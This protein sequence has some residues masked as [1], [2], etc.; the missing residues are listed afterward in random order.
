M[1]EENYKKATILL[2]EIAT[3]ER[4]LLATKDVSYGI[5]DVCK[6]YPFMDS[7]HKL[8]YELLPKDV[9]D[10]FLSQYKIAIESKLTFLK[11]EL[12]SL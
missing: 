7:T 5:C 9:I 11:K 6:P 2:K 4:H 10:T 12:E 3:I 8:V 1:T